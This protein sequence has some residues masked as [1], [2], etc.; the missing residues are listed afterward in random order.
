MTLKQ[1]LAPVSLIKFFYN[2][3]RERRVVHI[4]KTKFPERSDSIYNKLVTYDSIKSEIKTAPLRNLIYFVDGAP[5]IPT[6]FLEIVRA[7]EDHNS[8][9]R[10]YTSGTHNLIE[11]NNLEEDIKKQFH[12]TYAWTNL[13]WSRK[14]QALNPHKDPDTIVVLQIHGK[15]LWNFYKDGIDWETNKPIEELVMEKGDFLFFPKGTLHSA[16]TTGDED[17]LHLT[18]EI[19][20]EFDK[21]L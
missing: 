1:I 4:S 15:K 3:V 14:K 2:G 11:L 6:N 19:K 16:Q 17:S 10:N 20:T 21:G 12:S 9:L 18:I 13:Y 7:Q 8:I 5:H